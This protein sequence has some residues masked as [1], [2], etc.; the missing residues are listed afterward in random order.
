MQ[1]KSVW[2]S[3]HFTACPISMSQNDTP[4]A[5]LYVTTLLFVS[6]PSSAAT[7]ALQCFSS[8]IFL[9]KNSVKD[10]RSK[11][12]N[13][14]VTTLNIMYFYPPLP[15]KRRQG[16]WTEDWGLRTKSGNGKSWQQGLTRTL[17]S[18]VCIVCLNGTLINEGSTH[19]SATSFTTS[20]LTFFFLGP[21]YLKVFCQCIAKTNCLGSEAATEKLL[22][23]T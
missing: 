4:H 11:Q 16:W 7:N 2:S 22:C 21:E 6:F 3:S 13:H 14:N 9:D 18:W 8:F 1:Q 17:K 10:K 12:T 23:Q 20:V 19:S 5:E 15:K